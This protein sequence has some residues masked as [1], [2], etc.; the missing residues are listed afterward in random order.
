MKY[1]IIASIAI[2]CA[3][4]SFWGCQKEDLGNM[5]GIFSDTAQAGP[6]SEMAGKIND[7]PWSANSYTATLTP[8]NPGQIIITGKSDNSQTITLVVN[9]SKAGDYLLSRLTP[10]VAAYSPDSTGSILYKSNDT[11]CGGIINIDTIDT[12]NLVMTGEF[13]FIGGTSSKNKATITDGTFVNIGY[14]NTAANTQ[15][16]AKVNGSSW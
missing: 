3:A 6:V 15:F 9:N 5:D 11:L 14:I 8:G 16:A 10:G 1:F 2:I 4:G 13:N 7:V 12:T